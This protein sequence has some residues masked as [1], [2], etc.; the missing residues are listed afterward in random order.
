MHRTI[1]HL[2]V[3]SADGNGDSHDARPIRVV[4]SALPEPGFTGCAEIDGELLDARMICK[5]GLDDREIASRAVA[6]TQDGAHLRVRLEDVDPVR[7]QMV[8][9]HGDMPA[10]LA[11][12]IDNVGSRLDQYRADHDQALPMHKGTA[13]AA[14]FERQ[15]ICSAPP[16]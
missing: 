14:R 7:S 8:E 13:D 2:I 1:E 6:P 9:E 5:R 4:E 16:A 3:E 15:R 12:D 10:L 11:A